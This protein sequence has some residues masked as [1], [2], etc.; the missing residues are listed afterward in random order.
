M[1]QYR[2]LITV[3]DQTAYADDAPA[4]PDF[5]FHFDN[6]DDLFEIVDRV[7]SKALFAGDDETRTFCVGLKLL[8]HVLMQHRKEEMFADFAT[9]FGSFMKGLKSR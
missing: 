3:A 6:H 4:R 7:R 2:Y 1:S 8:G 5:S 9:S